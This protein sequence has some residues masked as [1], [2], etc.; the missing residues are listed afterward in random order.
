MFRN[1]LIVDD[2]TLLLTA[3]KRSFG[4]S[5]TVYTAET[6]D[7]AIALARSE[8][9]DLAFVDLILE[10]SKGI[11]LIRELKMINPKMVVMLVSAYASYDVAGDAVRA[12][13]F[14]V[15]SKPITYRTVAED[16]ESKTPP[17]PTAVPTLS[18]VE[19]EYIQRVLD[20]CNGNVS[21]AAECLGMAR[22]TLNRKLASRN[23]GP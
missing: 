9:I 14:K 18:E 12:G 10:S 4:R 19:R 5:R 16:L 11:D 15:K 21:R 20:D 17:D 22:S 13:A 1:I 7:Q 23:E 2:N 8:R 3:A 6:H